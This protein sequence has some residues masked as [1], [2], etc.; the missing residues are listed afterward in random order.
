M[1]DVCEESFQKLK[2]CLI[3]SPIL[4][5]PI[6]GKD[7][8]LLCDASL[9]GLGVGLM[10]ERNVIAYALRLLKIYE[11]TTQLITWSW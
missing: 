11:R 7:F 3:V 10:Q 1:S 9:L 6:E 8:V 4:S 5:L 2:T